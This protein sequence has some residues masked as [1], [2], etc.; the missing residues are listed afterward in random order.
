MFLI[1]LGSPFPVL[2]HQ[3]LK[4][5]KLINNATIRLNFRKPFLVIY[6]KDTINRILILEFPLLKSFIYIN[7]DVNPWVLEHGSNILFLQQ[8]NTENL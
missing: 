8:L 1:L 6:K 7:I 5:N 3:N 2:Q 4:A